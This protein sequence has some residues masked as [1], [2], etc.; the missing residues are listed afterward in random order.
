MQRLLEDF[1]NAATLYA[2][3]IE[4]WFALVALITFLFA[5]LGTILRDIGESLAPE[6]LLFFRSKGKRL[7]R[8]LIEE[9]NIFEIWFVAHT[10]FI[11]QVAERGQVR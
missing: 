11:P 6:K 9:S 8:F 5:T 3:N 4:N 10:L 2:L 7:A 1:A